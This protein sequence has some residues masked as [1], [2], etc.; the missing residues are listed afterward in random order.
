MRFDHLLQLAERPDLPE[1][2]RWLRRD[3]LRT[4]A[5]ALPS[6]LPEVL[7]PDKVHL[8]DDALAVDDLTV[9]RAAFLQMVV[10]GGG[11]ATAG[12]GRSLV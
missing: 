11:K 4:L 3:G 2:I 10:V 9:P 6:G 12:M 8:D 1:P 7:L 5:A